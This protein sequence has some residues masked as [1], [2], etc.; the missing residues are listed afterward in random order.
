MGN[1][2]FYWHILA[3]PSAK[4]FEISLLSYRYFILSFIFT[5]FLNYDRKLSIVI[6]GSCII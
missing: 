6:S 1:L 2:G 3:N 4:M 5:R